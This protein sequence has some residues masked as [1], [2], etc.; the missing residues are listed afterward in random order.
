MVEPNSKLLC[1]TCVQQISK[2]RNNGCIYKLYL[3]FFKPELFQTFKGHIDMTIGDQVTVIIHI[4]DVYADRIYMEK[5][6]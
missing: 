6:T 2:H 3:T 4:I 1:T 5:Q